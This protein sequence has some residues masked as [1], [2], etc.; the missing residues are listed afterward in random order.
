MEEHARKTYEAHLQR[1]LI[2]RLNLD[3][4]NKP[5]AARE[6]FEKDVAS[7]F[8]LKPIQLDKQENETKKELIT[9]K[10]RE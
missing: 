2:E 9:I 8:V 4:S 10:D 3:F 7:L 5:P 6:Q 1:I